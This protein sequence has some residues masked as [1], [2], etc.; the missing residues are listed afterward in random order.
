M[1]ATAI[2]HL[3]PFS[4][5]IVLVVTVTGGFSKE[6]QRI[7]PPRAH[8]IVPFPAETGVGHMTCFDH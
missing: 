4:L 8:V 7:T 3:H 1:K 6:S 2:W 5:P